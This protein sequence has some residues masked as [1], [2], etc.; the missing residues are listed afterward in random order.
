MVQLSKSIWWTHNSALSWLCEN[1]YLAQKNQISVQH[2]FNF[3][4]MQQRDL[5]L[6]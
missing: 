6:N 2:F 4:I 1:F 5:E 3:V